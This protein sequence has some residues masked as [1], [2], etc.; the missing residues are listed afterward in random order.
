M[1]VSRVNRCSLEKA[2]ASLP[3]VEYRPRM[4]NDR[5]AIDRPERPNAPFV[6]GDER[7]TDGLARRIREKNVENRAIRASTNEY[8]GSDL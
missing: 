1:D 7:R 4:Q 5:R 8:E 3:N 6:P 2:V